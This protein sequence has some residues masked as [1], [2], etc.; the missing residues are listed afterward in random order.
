MTWSRTSGPCRSSALLPLG[1][2]A[3]DLGGGTFVV[4]HLTIVNGVFEV[5]ATNGDSH[6]GGETFDQ[7][8]M[9]PFSIIS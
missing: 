2:L 3:D 6:L 4:P 9:H 7:C 5:V 1:F 8:V